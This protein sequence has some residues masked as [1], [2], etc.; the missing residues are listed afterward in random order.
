MLEKI[1]EQLEMRVASLE[2]EAKGSKVEILIRSDYRDFTEDISFKKFLELAK[3]GEYEFKDYGEGITIMTKAYKD[4]LEDDDGG[5]FD[6]EYRRFE[7]SFYS[8]CE[9]LLTSVGA[10]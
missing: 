3:D 8:L 7:V 5:D 10:K 1:I 2:K 4:W 9:A 6:G